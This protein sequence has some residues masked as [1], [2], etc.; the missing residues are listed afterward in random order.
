MPQLAQKVAAAERASAD[1][2]K[3]ATRVDTNEQ[4]DR[5]LEFYQNFSRKIPLAAMGMG[6]LGRRSRKL[7]AQLG[8]VLTYAHLGSAQ[9]DGQLSV[10]EARRAVAASSQKSG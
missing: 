9:V 3:F 4:L 8:S 5:L 1:I 6:K 7:L 10:A 2:C